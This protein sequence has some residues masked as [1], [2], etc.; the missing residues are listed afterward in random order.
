MDSLYFNMNDNLRRK[1]WNWNLSDES[2]QKSFIF[3]IFWSIKH[4]EWKLEFSFPFVGRFLN[5]NVNDKD[6][7]RKHKHK[8][9]DKRYRVIMDWKLKLPDNVFEFRTMRCD[10][11]SSL[12][13]ISTCFSFK[14]F[15]FTTKPQFQRH[16]LHHHMLNVCQQS[17]YRSK[18]VY[19]RDAS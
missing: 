10:C 7:S 15:A 14:I 3:P 5:S 6:R 11:F 16:Y 19:H 18:I 17:I 4:I 13:I 1:Q 9:K 12:S 2:W 8:K